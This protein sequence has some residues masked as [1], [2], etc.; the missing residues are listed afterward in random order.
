MRRLVSHLRGQGIRVWVDNEMLTPG[1]PIWEHEIERAIKAADAVVALMSPDAKDSEWVRREIS[2]A[3]QYRKRIFPVLVR[4]DEDSSIT[5]R[6]ITRQFVDLRGN[7]S[8]GLNDLSSAITPYLEE[9]I[10]Q[11]DQSQGSEDRI[12]PGSVRP[13]APK[14]P[15]TRQPAKGPVKERAERQPPMSTDHDPVG[16]TTKR[17]NRPQLF[18]IG[19]ILALGIVALGAYLGLSQ[20]NRGKQQAFQNATETAYFS[21]INTIEAANAAANAARATDD[22]LNKLMAEAQATEDDS[23]NLTAEAQATTDASYYLTA[24]SQATEDAKSYYDPFDD[25]LGKWFLGDWNK[26]SWDGV[27]SLENGALHLNILEVRNGFSQ[28]LTFQGYVAA[29]FDL[30]VDILSEYYLDSNN[31]PIDVFCPGIFF[32]EAG[33]SYYAFYICDQKYKV[34]YFDG[35]EWNDIVSL[36]ENTAINPSAW[37]TLRVVALGSGFELYINGVK[38]DSF[39]DSR[40]LNGQ[41]GLWFQT[42][43][44]IGEI[45]GVIR[46]DNFILNNLE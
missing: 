39:S 44:E 21:E 8:S 45:P 46:F 22:A 9:L 18:Y 15:I 34:L 29:D 41:I 11:G 5:L 27:S 40:N 17:K 30:T 43:T 37:N 32:R 14:A 7:E 19:S 26:D 33:G 16:A 28:R 4:G 38:I 42:R 13:A 6:L 2:L 3:D 25:D 12:Q 36:T 24:D 10:A 35:S 23:Y 31:G 1:T 20:A